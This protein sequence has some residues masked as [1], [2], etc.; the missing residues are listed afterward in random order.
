MVD[1]FNFRVYTHPS[2]LTYADDRWGGDLLQITSHPFFEGID[3]INLDQTLEPLFVPQVLFPL[4][5][6]NRNTQLS[7]ALDST[8]FENLDGSS[9]GKVRLR[10]CLK[11]LKIELSIDKLPSVLRRAG[12]DCRKEA[13]RGRGEKKRVYKI[14]FQKVVQILLPIS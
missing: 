8:Y 5:K 6:L 12:I 11:L 7:D 10:T 14:G 9:P 3:W 1:H 13:L 4:K 2:F